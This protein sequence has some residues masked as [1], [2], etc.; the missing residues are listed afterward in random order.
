MKVWLEKFN[1]E[2]LSK[3]RI[4]EKDMVISKNPS[5]K[6]LSSKL[7]IMFKDNWKRGYSYVKSKPQLMRSKSVPDVMRQQLFAQYIAYMQTIAHSVINYD[8]S[9]LSPKVVEEVCHWEGE[10]GYCIHLSVLLYGLTTKYNVFSKEDISYFQ[11]LY[12]FPLR[13]DMPSFL[14][15][16]SRQIGLHAW[17]TVQGSVIDVTANQN[18]KFFDFGFTDIS[19]ILGE[20]HN[21]YKLLGYKETEETIDWYFELFSSHMG[22]TVDEWI[23]FHHEESKRM[24]E[25]Q[26][27]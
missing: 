16:A 13:K 1:G 17:L 24:L 14:P 18:M 7:N 8:F 19:L 20:Y 9:E 11:G 26:E 6:E 22:M 21:D 10:G 23:E 2:G 12:D 3:I 5:Q 15:L 27:E 25:A 4:S